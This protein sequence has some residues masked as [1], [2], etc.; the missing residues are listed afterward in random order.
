MEIVELMAS[1]LSTEAFALNEAAKRLDKA[2]ADALAELFKDLIVQE[3]SLIFCGVGKSGLVGQKL[4]ATFTSLGLPGHFLHPTEAL[5]GD[6]GIL[7]EKDAIVLISYSGKSEEI[8]KL[9]PFL[10]VGPE[11]RIALV[12]NVESPIAKMCDIVFDCQVHKEAC[13]NNQA[14][15]TSSTLTMA[16]GDAMAVLLEH[17]TGLSKEG[18]AKYHPGGK[19]GKSLRLKVSDLLVS[20]ENC[21]L[22]GEE[23]LFKTAILKMTEFPLG[24][25]VVLGANDELKGL[26]VEG[27]VRRLLSKDQFD[28]NMN[29]QDVANQSPITIREDQLANDALALMEGRKNPFSVLPVLGAE[30]QFLG[31]LRLHDLFKEGL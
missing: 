3:G 1:V 25:A 28:L 20:K 5:H 27:D 12:G 17:I 13:L 11:R 19:L 31:L 6:L 14:P 8:F 24:A 30:G 22:L 23:D 2:Q 18:F 16:I 9:N 15:T 7:R 4:A 10:C 29:V 21:G 26:I